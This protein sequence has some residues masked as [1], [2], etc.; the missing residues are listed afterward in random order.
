MFTHLAMIDSG[1]NIRA[2]FTKIFQRQRR[3]CK[4][5]EHFSYHDLRSEGRSAPK[6]EQTS[7]HGFA[8]SSLLVKPFSHMHSP[9][10][11]P[12]GRSVFSRLSRS[13]FWQTMEACAVSFWRNV[14]PQHHQ[15]YHHRCV[16]TLFAS[17]L[18]IPPTLT[19]KFCKTRN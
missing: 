5:R 18:N 15:E 12:F 3:R 7:E 8:I 9:L 16:R 13:L 10:I 1:G 11:S 17:N 2:S 6:A 19:N 4:S 14:K